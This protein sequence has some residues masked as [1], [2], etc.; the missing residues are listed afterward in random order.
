MIPW[1]LKEAHVQIWS[2]R[3]CTREHRMSSIKKL[4]DLISRPSSDLVLSLDVNHPKE[5]RSL[6]HSRDSRPKW[7]NIPRLNTLSRRNLRYTN[8]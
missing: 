6:R 3:H 1:K 8:A 2:H 5:R 4:L 7:T